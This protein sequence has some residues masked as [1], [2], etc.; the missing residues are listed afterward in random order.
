MFQSILTD[1]HAEWFNR[2]YKYIWI[3][4]QYNFIS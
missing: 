4:F 3:E 1:S 2:L